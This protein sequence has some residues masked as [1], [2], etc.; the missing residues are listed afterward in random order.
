M[1]IEKTVKETY[2]NSLTQNYMDR[3]FY[4]CLKR[5]GNSFEAENLTSDI[6]LNIITSLER[7]N[8]PDNFDAWVWGVARNCY[9]IWA[10]KKYNQ[11]ELFTTLDINDYKISDNTE[12]IDNKVI[13]SETINLLRRELAFI[14]SEYRN[15]V[16][17]YYIEDRKIKDIATSLNLPEGT[18]KAKLFRARKTLKEGMNMAREFGVR[19]YKPENV[20]FYASGKNPTTPWKAVER[21]LPKN[22]L[23]EA[24]NNPLTIEEL[25]IELGVAVPYMEEEIELLT[26]AT[27]LK[28]INNKYVTNIFI[29]SKE[30]QHEIWKTQR[31]NSKKQSELLNDIVTD[32][33]GELRELGIVR[34]DMSDQD[35]KWWAVLYAMDCLIFQLNGY[36]LHFPE[37]RANGETWGFMGFEQYDA[38]EKTTTGRNGNGNEQAMFTSY[39]ISDYNLWNRIGEMNCSQTLF[40]SDILKNNRISSNFSQSEKLIW[41]DI[42]NR[43]AHLDENGNIIPDILILSGDAKEKCIDILLSHPLVKEFIKVLQETFDKIVEILK[44][45]SHSILEKQLIYCAS[46]MILNIRMMTVHDMVENEQLILPENPDES[47]IAMW[48]EYE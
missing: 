22:I 27:L 46:M 48:I 31:E 13:K 34:N 19:S 9:I 6:L 30:C 42:E 36:S 26:N 45:N 14:S 15:I 23:L 41:K 21:S 43:F 8:K 39:K 16:V 18:V 33:L 5:T 20:D 32:S 2:L 37:K 10:K 40:L 44:N 3:L 7:G 24:D 38:P 29:A 25:S 28:K 47:T 12:N 1:A 11:S 35:L 4:F 17:A